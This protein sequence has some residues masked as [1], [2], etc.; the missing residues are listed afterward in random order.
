MKAINIALIAALMLLAGCAKVRIMDASAV[1]MTKKKMPN[2]KRLKQIGDVT[3]E[4]CT[5]TFG[6]SGNI[7][8]M[9]EA[10]KDA[11]KK[12]GADF[13]LDARFFAKGGCVSVEGT[14]AKLR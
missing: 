2:G 9:D 8:L 5:D 4:F 14:G 13:I 6:D 7:G 10:I 11:Q 12:S 3:G 1:S